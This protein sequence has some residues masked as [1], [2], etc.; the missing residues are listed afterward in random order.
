MTVLL[1][2]ARIGEPT[3]TSVKLALERL[4]TC[5]CSLVYLE[6]FRSGKD[7]SAA[8][9]RAGERFLSRVDPDVID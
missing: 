8:G 4:F 5:M 2:I 3:V 6:V 9:K 1:A 7:F